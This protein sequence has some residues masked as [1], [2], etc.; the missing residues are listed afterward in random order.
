MGNAAKNKYSDGS[1][2]VELFDGIDSFTAGTEMLGNVHLNLKKPLEAYSIT[3]RLEGKEE[4]SIIDYS[5]R[6]GDA[7]Y[8]VTTK[9]VCVNESNT[10]VRFDNRMP[11]VGS[12]VYP[13]RLTIPQDAP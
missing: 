10:V 3:V 9:R 12:S 1:I 4:A 11:P 6:R 13:F 2:R 5:S 7:T 8:Y